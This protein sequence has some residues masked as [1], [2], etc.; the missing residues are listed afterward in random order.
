MFYLDQCT[1]YSNELG[2]GGGGGVTAVPLLYDRGTM[3]RIY[4]H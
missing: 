1:V 2:G 4:K 3:I